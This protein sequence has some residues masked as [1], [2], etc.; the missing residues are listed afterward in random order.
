MNKAQKITIIL[1]ILALAAIAFFTPK[2]KL[3]RIDDENYIKTEQSSALYARCTGETKLH[4]D[5]IF[6]Y[7]GATGAV[8]AILLFFLK[9]KN[10]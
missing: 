7:W 8:C 10:E 4:W 5:K 6:I 2:Y 3:T 9:G 1:G